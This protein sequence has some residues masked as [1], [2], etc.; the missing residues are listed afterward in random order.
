MIKSI[1]LERFKKFENSTIQF[2]PFTVLM[3]ENSSGKTTVLQAVNLALVSLS[4]YELVTDDGKVAR[5]RGKGVG[6]TELPGIELAD[7]REAYFAKISRS[8]RTKGTVGANIIVTDIR[9]NS[10]KLQMSS[11]FGSFNIKC[12]SNPDDLIR[13]PTIHR[14]PPLYISGFVGLTPVEERVF[15]V[16]LQDRLRTGHVSTIIRNLVLDT[17]VHSP[18]RF[19]QLKKRLVH[20]FNFHLDTVLFNEEKDL[21][22]QAQYSEV[23]KSSSLSLD[24]NASGSGF[25]QILQILAPIYRYCPEKTEIVLLD[26]PDAHLHPNLQTALANS[27]KSIQQELGIQII[28]STHSTSIIRATEPNNVVPISIKHDICHP[29]VND[30]EIEEIIKEKIDS[31][32]LAKSVISGKLIFFE[33]SNLDLWERIDSILPDSVFSGSNTSPIIKGRGK[34]DRVPFQLNSVLSELTGEEIEIIFIRDRDGLSDEWITRIKDY[35]AERNVNVQI[36]RYFELESYLLDSNLIQL[37]IK[38]RDQEKTEPT[39]DEIE[40]QIIHSLKNTIS[41]ARYHYDDDLEEEIHQ[42]AM[43]M[44]LSKYRNSQTVKSEV[45]A[46]HDSLEEL[47]D[48]ES[49]RTYGKGKEALSSILTW[50]QDDYGI[51][52]NKKALVAQINNE[53]LDVELKEILSIMASKEASPAPEGL[54]ALDEPDGAESFEDDFQYLLFEN[55]D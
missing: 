53:N 43:L 41:L 46:W 48:I 29:L 39:I 15:P 14:K 33:D 32:N 20:D 19:E 11:F 45:R 42:V 31:Y 38:E 50:L 2:R 49:L 35:A 1:K 34:T 24:F 52:L 6:L 7:F 40:T 16:A 36:T 17:K 5:V 4:S 8:S 9:D 22:V 37:A 44:S 18:G 27:L 51:N 25:M 30:G 26:E 13:T 23:V 21:F 10:Y 54:T 12:N 28:I 55:V 3:G 47:T